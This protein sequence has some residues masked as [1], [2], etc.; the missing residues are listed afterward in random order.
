MGARAAGPASAHGGEVPGGDPPGLGPNQPGEVPFGGLEG[1][2]HPHPVGPGGGQGGVGPEEV[3]LGRPAHLQELCH[4]PPLGGHRLDPPVGGGE[5]GV[6]AQDPE[7]GLEGAGGDGLLRRLG[8][9]P[10]GPGPGFGGGHG[11]PG[12]AAV[13]QGVLQVQVPL[14]QGLVELRQVLEVEAVDRRHHHGVRE[15]HHRPHEV[16]PRQQPGLGFRQRLPGLPGLRPSHPGLRVVGQRPPHGLRRGKPVRR[17][18]LRLGGEWK[19]ARREDQHGEGGGGPEARRTA[20]GARRLRG[21]GC[22]THGSVS[23]SVIRRSTSTPGSVSTA[24]ASKSGSGNRRWADGHGGREAEEQE[25][26]LPGLDPEGK[27]REEALQRAEIA[28]RTR[29]DAL[30]EGHV[31]RG[32][33]LRQE[34]DRQPLDGQ[35][36]PGVEAHH[37]RQPLRRRPRLVFG[38]PPDLRQV[39]ALDP[40]HERLEEGALAREVP[41]QAPP[42]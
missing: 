36:R 6:Q 13:V 11:A 39:P 2:R 4:P 10:G 5:D 15:A 31:A 26:R 27:L 20:A 35:H 28:A 23:G 19:S 18:R 22:V 7:V 33:G 1:G 3:H 37:V 41:V 17:R 12:A 40:P 38:D 30:L 16:D 34:Q 8:A 42:P 29:A 25:A 9:L 21:F 32:G 24:R 14:D